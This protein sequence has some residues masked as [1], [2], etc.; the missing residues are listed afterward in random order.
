MITLNVH[1]SLEAVGFVAFV[2]GK[3][4]AFRWDGDGETGRGGITANV[5]SGFYH[6]HLFVP[7]GREA[8][9]LAVLGGIAREA[10]G[11]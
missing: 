9:A 11:E 5:V 4:A 2:A 6:D 1:S 10:G 3:L 8:D 7:V